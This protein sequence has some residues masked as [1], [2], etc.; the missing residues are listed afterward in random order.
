M[1]IHSITIIGCGWLGLP[2]AESLVSK[3]YKVNGTTTTPAKLEGI[4]AIGGA[5]FILDLSERTD[6]SYTEACFNV[7]LIICA[8]PPSASKNQDFHHD[9][10][11]EQLTKS[12]EKSVKVIYVS[13]TSIYPKHAGE[14][15]ESSTINEKTTGNMLLLNAEKAVF[16]HSESNVVLRLG[17]LLGYNR[18]AGK[19]FAGKTASGRLQPVNYIHR[20]DVIGFI[21]KLIN[22]KQVSGVF[23]LVTPKDATREEVYA[24]NSEKHG[25]Q[26]CTWQDDGVQRKII[27]ES[28]GIDLNYDFKYPDPLQF[29]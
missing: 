27:S 6:P 4:R 2:L 11:I 10:Q 24:A 16:Q 5:P 21:H 8:V 20:D 18:I 22:Q 23:N 9:Q 13:S 15:T 14:F 19:Y 25:F 7:D 29:K 26:I 3:G 1:M 28:V 17:G 12:L